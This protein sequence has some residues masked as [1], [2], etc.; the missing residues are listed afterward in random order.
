MPVMDGFEATKLIKTSRPSVPVIALTANVIKE[1]IE[2]CY[3]SGMSY[4]LS[5]PFDPVQLKSTVIKFTS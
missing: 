5:K 3:A 1:E 2:K 4:H